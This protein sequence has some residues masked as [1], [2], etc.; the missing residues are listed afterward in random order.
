MLVFVFNTSYPVFFV[1]LHMRPSTKPL[2]SLGDKPFH[3]KTGILK[4]TSKG[5]P[6]AKAILARMVFLII[7]VIRVNR[8]FEVNVKV[9]PP[10]HQVIMTGPYQ[11]TRHL[12]A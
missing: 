1:H 3:P 6:A 2:A 8:Y 5:V 11:F 12:G 7:T 4:E 10:D 9:R